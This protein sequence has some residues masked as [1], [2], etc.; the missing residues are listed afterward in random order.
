MISWTESNG[1]DLDVRA[2]V[3]TAAGEPVG[4]FGSSAP[5]AL[6]TLTDAS[7]DFPFVATNAD[8]AFFAWQ[9][10]G[11]RSADGSPPACA[12]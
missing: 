5:L 2:R 11:V 4:G 6:G 7:Q 9:D 12:A 8:H 1:A 10:G 3:F